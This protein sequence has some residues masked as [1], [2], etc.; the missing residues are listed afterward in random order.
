MHRHS[1]K[2]IVIVEFALITVLTILVLDEHI[3]VEVLEQP[4]ESLG[5]S[6]ICDPGQ[7][8]NV[9]LVQESNPFYRQ[10]RKNKMASRP[11]KNLQ[12]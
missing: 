3:V 10:T 4:M 7:R 12:K 6:G 2:E 1:V 8:K 5:V 9:P 11:H